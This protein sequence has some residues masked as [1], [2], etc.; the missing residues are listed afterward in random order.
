MEKLSGVPLGAVWSGMEIQDPLAV[1]KA[2]ARYQKS[3]TSCSFHRF[4]SLYYAK[5]IEI[6]EHTQNPLYT[7]C[8]GN[9]VK[10]SE[11]TVGPSTGRDFSDHGRMKIEFDRGPCKTNL[12]LEPT[13]CQLMLSSGQNLEGYALA[14][15]RREFTCVQ[16]LPRLPISS[17]TLFGPG[18]YQPT[19]QK[20]LKALQWYLDIC[21]Y[22]LPSDGSIQSPCLWHGDLHADNI[23]VNPDN[24]TEIVGII[25]WQSTELTPL[26][27]RA[28]QPHF[29][30]YDGPPMIGLERPSL[31]HNLA[32]L[33]TAAQTEANKLYLNQALSA[34]YK[35]PVHLQ[36]P[37]PY[38]AMT[39][40]ET[41]SFD[42]L[43]LA[44]HL[45]VDGEATYLAQ[46]VELEKTWSQL[47]GVS[48]LETLPSF[49]INISSE[50]RAEIQADAEG[51]N[52][53]MQT[54]QGSQDSLRELFP[55]NRMIPNDQY[56]EARDAL[57]QMKEQVI[58]KYS[59]SESDREIW[60][61]NWPFEA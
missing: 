52:K 32:E 40:R 61:S 37:R 5:D 20:K 46:V 43:L 45:L 28:R 29:L 56:D 19:R 41:S 49:P 18:T 10:S 12:R 1:V 42:L 58:E 27:M 30:D 57:R 36:I 13:F 31:P 8:H 3:W 59:K 6:D 21:K 54:L 23:F 35:A 53:G 51:A 22:L 24:P 60:R 14:L 2:I 25:D 15:G 7:D 48:T 4:G 11:F 44:P 33:D 9:A 16:S 55:A 34:L 17:A 38:R 50:E 39:F 26:F 47:P